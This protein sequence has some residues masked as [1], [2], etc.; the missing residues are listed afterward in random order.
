M[1]KVFLLFILI[2]FTL[3]IYGFTNRDESFRLPKAAETILKQLEET[4]HVLDTVSEKIW[5]GWTNYKDFP[6]LFEFENRLRILVGHPN[7]PEDFE[8]LEGRKV[9][10]KNVFVDKNKIVPM[11]LTEPLRGG[12]GILP[13]G[14][15][16]DGKRISVVSISL[17]RYE[18]GKEDEDLRYRTENQIILL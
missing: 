11:E 10:G 14:T 2:L 12:G 13:Y 18:E 7:P 6:F 15:T 16:E 3:N 9:S 8:L 17:R 5:Q 1:R 4:Y